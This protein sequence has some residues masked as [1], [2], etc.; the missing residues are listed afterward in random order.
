MR[1]YRSPA[2]I[3][4]THS[5]L[6]QLGGPNPLLQLQ[7]VPST[8]VITSSWCPMGKKRE[9]K[10]RKC[11]HTEP[12]LSFSLAYCVSKA[13]SQLLL[14][15]FPPSH[16]CHEDSLTNAG[17]SLWKMK[18]FSV[19]H[20]YFSRLMAAYRFCLQNACQI[21]THCW[22]LHPPKPFLT[23]VPSAGNLLPRAFSK[24]QQF[25]QQLPK[26]YLE[27]HRLLSKAFS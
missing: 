11:C 18:Y 26:K 5:Q 2:W 1:F 16:E 25:L 27:I 9:K 14:L 7:Q 8:L 24:H 13:S 6:C 4:V 3:Q 10:Q 22:L 20:Y 21:I 17:K 12:L 23:D 15:T 19:K